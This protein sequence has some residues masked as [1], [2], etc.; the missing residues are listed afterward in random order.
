MSLT[1]ARNCI[2]Y[3]TAREGEILAKSVWT[4]DDTLVACGFSV[5]ANISQTNWNDV[6]WSPNIRCD[7]MHTFSF[8]MKLERVRQTSDSNVTFL[9]IKNLRLRLITCKYLQFG[10]ENSTISD[11]GRCYCKSS[12]CCELI[13]SQQLGAYWNSLNKKDFSNISNTWMKTTQFMRLWLF[14]GNIWRFYQILIIH[15]V[16]KNNFDNNATKAIFWA[17]SIH[18]T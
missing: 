14:A 13:N 18:W 9:I 10:Q 11:G 7:I 2:V 3:N 16:N 1:T 12:I 17:R 5:Q 15:S 6:C 4:V 8:V